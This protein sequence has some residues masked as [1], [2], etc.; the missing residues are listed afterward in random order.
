MPPFP[1]E[2]TLE[3]AAERLSYPGARSH[4]PVPRTGVGRRA[5]QRVEIQPLDHT[6]TVG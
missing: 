4:E 3:A 5:E 1:V 2:L 6:L